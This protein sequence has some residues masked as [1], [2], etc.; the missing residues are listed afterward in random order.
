MFNIWT[1][2]GKGYDK[3]PHWP[4]FTGAYVGPPPKRHCTALRHATNYP[5]VVGDA[6]VRTVGAVVLFSNVRIVSAV[7]IME[8]TTGRCRYASWRTITPQR[9]VCGRRG[10]LGQWLAR[11][12]HCAMVDA[13][14]KRSTR[15]FRERSCV[16]ACK[17]RSTR[18]LVIP[19]GKTWW[20]VVFFAGW[21][22]CQ[23][24]YNTVHW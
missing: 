13:V 16:R 4:H 24:K 20:L 10:R 3:I 12:N 2:D 22:W 23:T 15:P 5:Q 9:Q 7:A 14:I 8:C 1:P 19:H 17:M 6:G 18:Y 21:T 11:H